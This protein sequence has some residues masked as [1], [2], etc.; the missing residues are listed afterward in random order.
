[1]NQAYYA[2]VT[3]QAFFSERLDNRKDRG[4]TA[5]EYGLMIGLI[6]VAIIATLVLLG[7]KL[8]A[9][10]ADVNAKLPTPPAAPTTP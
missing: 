9:L 1:M 6:A 2:Y 3:L 8:N 4:A 5:V 10:F 7:P